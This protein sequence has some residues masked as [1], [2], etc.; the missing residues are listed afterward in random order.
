MKTGLVLVNYNDYD[1][2]KKF[3]DSIYTYHIISKIVI[4]D[5]KSTDDSLI[6]LKKIE[7]NK[8][9]ILENTS[10]KGYGSGI[11]LGSKYL[12]ELY[13]ECNIIVSNSDIIID[14]EKSIK[15]LLNGLNTCSLVAPLVI[16]KN[17]YNRGWK[18]INSFQ[19]GLLNLPI[20][21]KKLKN[22]ILYYKDDYYKNKKVFVDVVSGCFFI[23]KSQALK[24]ADYFDENMFLYYEENTIATKLKNNN[25]KI[26]LD[27]SVNVI[28]NHSVTI[29]KSVSTIRKFKLLKR[30]QRYY[31]KTYQ[32]T[33][34]FGM[35]WLYL[36]SY[37]TLLLIIIREKIKYKEK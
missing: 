7:N 12:I 6:K 36:T 17:N 32:K 10:N 4:V 26:L 21:S 22:K 9:I 25:Q 8:I 16:E 1:E 27:T 23:I 37:L 11:N 2:I 29:D 33:S 13:G 31:Y 20:I 24:D 30:S 28:H 15:E 35:L 14:S 19:E 18:L 34:I 3:I 5:N